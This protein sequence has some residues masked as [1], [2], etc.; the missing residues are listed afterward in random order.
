[1]DTP[2]T[3]WPPRTSTTLA[4]NSTLGAPTVTVG[5]VTKTVD[6]GTAG[7]NHWYQFYNASDLNTMR[8]DAWNRNTNSVDINGGFCTDKVNRQA[9]ST[10]YTWQSGNRWDAYNYLVYKNGP[11]VGTTVTPNAPINL[12]LTVSDTQ[13]NLPGYVGKT[14]TVQSPQPGNIWLPGHCVN[15]AREEVPCSSSSGWVNEVTIPTIANDA[16]SVTLL[17][18]NGSATGTK[19][20]AKWLK[21]GVYFEP[22]AASQCT[23]LS[24]DITKAQNIE[25]PGISGWDK[26]ISSMG[27]PWPTA[28]F[29]GKPRVIDGVLQ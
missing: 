4:W 18:A 5:G 9:N 1:V 17:N 21:R 6:W 29:N 15:A 3:E 26:T 7:N 28:L 27:L 11:K 16:G 22:I 14:I 10:Y 23:S 8:C 25:L 12:S 19:Y 24:T 20:F 2:S 13:G